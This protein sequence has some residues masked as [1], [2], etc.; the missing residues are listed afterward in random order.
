MERNA[1]TC[2]DLT[3]GRCLAALYRL[4]NGQHG[5]QAE[6][7]ATYWRSY[8]GMRS[9]ALGY[10]YIPDGSRVSKILRDRCEYPKPMYA[11][12]TRHDDL[13]RQDVE[14]YLADTVVTARQRTVYLETLEDLLDWSGNLDH[15]DVTHIQG[16]LSV[17]DADQL[18]EMIYRLMVVLIR[19][20]VDRAA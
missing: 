3:M 7:Y 18:A 1:W 19:E 20:S 14:A 10:Q 2:D 15:E 4:A 5:T 9:E 12:Y 16:Y 11:Y 6:W 8:H 13:L 17:P